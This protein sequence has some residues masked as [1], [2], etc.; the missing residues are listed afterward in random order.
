VTGEGEP[1]GGDHNGSVTSRHP[2]LVYTALRFLLFVVPF[3]LLLILRVDMVWA[4][5][6]A[7]LGSSVA[8][9]FVLGPYREQLSMS[10]TER[11]E[12]VKQRMAEREQAEDAWDDVHRTE[13]SESPDAQIDP[14]ESD[15]RH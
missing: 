5:L 6:I 9:I 13:P 10:L 1:L 7:V 15:D 4:L 3:A 14:E 8:S 11:N 12:Q 2:F